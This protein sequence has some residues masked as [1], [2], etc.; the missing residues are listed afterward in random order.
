LNGSALVERAEASLRE[1][2]PITFRG[3]FYHISPADQGGNGGFCAEAGS[4]G[5]V[6]P[7]KRVW[8]FGGK[9]LQSGQ[10][11]NKQAPAAAGRSSRG[12]NG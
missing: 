9:L 10:R 5:A 6:V 11:Q 4:G 7:A 2:C 8:R 12:A 1:A 3:A